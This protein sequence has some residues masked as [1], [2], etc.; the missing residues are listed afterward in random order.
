TLAAGQTEYFRRRFDMALAR[1]LGDLGGR[2]PHLVEGRE[3]WSEQEF[4]DRAPANQS[5]LLGR[6][7]VGSAADVGHA[8]QAARRMFP[9][10]RRRPWHERAEILRR[11]AELI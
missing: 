5:L 2:H 6:F 4:E 3:L 7:P 11:A 8:V 9:E 1:V 10:W